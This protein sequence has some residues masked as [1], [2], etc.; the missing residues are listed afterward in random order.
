MNS[1]NSLLKRELLGYFRT[2]VAYIFLAVFLVAS[3]GCT[4]FL[5]KFFENNQADLKAFFAFHP[6]LY[7]VFVPAI[8]MRLWSEELRTGTIELLM[9]LPISI[10]ETV[11]AKF[12]AAWLFIGV[13][14]FLTTPIWITVNFLGAP[15]NGVIFSSYIGSFLMGGAF[16]AIAAMASAFTKNQVIAFIIS[17]L[18]SLVLVLSGWGVFSTALSGFLPVWLV[19]A[20]ANI[21]FMTHF[22]NISKGLIDSRDIIYFISL[23]ALALTVNGL[24]IQKL[25]GR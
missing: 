22:N 24:A 15:D 25:K 23:I 10:A 4:F 13:A 21:G 11:L 17:V 14:L 9:T 20:V 3:M 19:D 8:G 7:L 5:G 6:W 12:L 1:L 18:I 2:P 16:L